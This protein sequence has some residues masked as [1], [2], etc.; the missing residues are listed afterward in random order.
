[1]KRTIHKKLS[2]S[3]ITIAAYHIYGGS[4]DTDT[5]PPPSSAFH[6]PTEAPILHPLTEDDDPQLISGNFQTCI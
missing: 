5:I 3:K 6:E 1:M 4:I 2:L